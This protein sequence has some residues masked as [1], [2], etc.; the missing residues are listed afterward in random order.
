MK[1][2]HTLPLALLACALPAM[3]PAATMPI[4]EPGPRAGLVE[5]PAG[6]AVLGNAFERVQELAQADVVN[7]SLYVGELGRSEVMVDRFWIAPT[8]V[9]NEMYLAYVAEAAVMP[10]PD[11]AVISSELRQE[12]IRNG[13][14]PDGD[15]ENLNLGY[16]FDE[17]EQARWWMENW[18]DEA[19]RWEM[20]PSR[21]LEPVVFVSY[22]DALGYCEWAGL[23]MPLEAEWVRAARGDSD[24]DY[25]W[26]AE[27]D[28]TRVAFQ[29]TR[30]DEIKYR[31]LPVG[32]LDN[33]SPFGIVDMAGQ[34]WE[35]TEDR[36]RA[37]DAA[38]SIEDRV[39]VTRD[40]GGDSIVY[41]NFETSRYV[42]KGGSFVNDKEQLRI[43]MRVGMDAEVP[44]QVL[45]FRVAA[46]DNRLGDVAYTRAR[47]V[48]SMVLGGQPARL[49]DFAR[50]IGVEKR[51]YSDM[52][53]VRAAR[54]APEA[55]LREPELPEEYAVFGAVRAVVFT[56]LADPFADYDH[57][58]I[59][60]IEKA[61]EADGKLPPLGVLC[62]TVP[63]LSGKGASNAE[64]EPIAAGEYVLAYF[65][66]LRKRE[67]EEF[68]G[69]TEDTKEEEK[70]AVPEKRLNVDISGV[71]MVAGEPQV[72]VIDKD[73]K[74]VLSLPLVNL[75][76]KVKVQADRSQDA[77]AAID[78]QRNR[79]R[80]DME[81][82]GPGTKTYFLSIGLRPLNED[83]SFALTNVS[84]WDAGTFEIVEKTR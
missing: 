68:G 80:I 43:D 3:L 64:G 69:Y 44:A 2:L 50:S 36:Y 70:L 4:Q 48:N 14:D 19:Y 32:M 56:P 25:P 54:Q 16:K 23:R 45:G 82:P 21:A 12:L 53:A 17:L 26:G 81:F 46:S 62:S 40:D 33:A 55:P 84:D 18:Q 72:L 66:P 10:P 51:K 20:P 71:E 6:R 34:V 65:P 35:F 78:L 67:I 39:K 76:N 31:R 75:N 30:P 7:A 58:S 11:W 59:S 24:Q 29:S 38:S 42:I 79:L 5:I 13:Q 52:G 1:P 37:Y 77:A 60:K 47:D 9:T 57:S 8:P 27:F 22:Q 49:L 73:A 28:A 41:P 15:G 61:A 74:A 83:A 63:F